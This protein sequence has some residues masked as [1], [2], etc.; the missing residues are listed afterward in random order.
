MGEMIAGESL[1]IAYCLEDKF[2]EFLSD[3]ASLKTISFMLLRAQ[4]P[5]S[6]KVGDNTIINL[7]LFRLI[8]NKIFSCILILKRAMAE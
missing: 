8:M 6:L 1:K 7:N 4:K 3:A 2:E 5:L